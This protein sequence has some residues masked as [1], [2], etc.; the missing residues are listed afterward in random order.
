MIDE[1]IDLLDQLTQLLLLTVKLAFDAIETG[2]ELLNLLVCLLLPDIFITL[3][4]I[5]NVELVAE[6]LL[7]VLRVD[8]LLVLLLAVDRDEIGEVRALLTLSDL[9]HNAHDDVLERILSLALLLGH[10]D[11]VTWHVQDV[12]AGEL[13][14]LLQDLI[15]VDEE[16]APKRLV[17]ILLDQFLHA[18]VVKN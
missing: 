4:A 15:L 1:R 8:T 3:R 17:L 12:I 10:M 7:H 14:L 9:D 5:Q 16:V 13:A 6:L 11:Q 2:H 18:R